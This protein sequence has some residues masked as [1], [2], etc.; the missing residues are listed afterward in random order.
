MLHTK[1]FTLTD[2]IKWFRDIITRRYANPDYLFT[3]RSLAEA[4]RKIDVKKAIVLLAYFRCRGYQ[5]NK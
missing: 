1:I 5:G 4:F 3:Q 2:I